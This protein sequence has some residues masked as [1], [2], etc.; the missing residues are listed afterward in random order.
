DGHSWC[1]EANAT[2]C[3]EKSLGALNRAGHQGSDPLI[4]S[5][6]GFIWD[7][8]LQHNLTIHN[9]GVLGLSSP[10]PS[11]STWLQVYADYTN[12]AGRIWYNT[13][14]GAPPVLPKYSSTNVSGFNL[15]IPDQMRADGFLAEFNAAQ[16]NGTWPT[17]NM[18]YLPND[19]T[20]GGSPGYPTARAELADNDLALGRVVEAVTKSSFWTNTVIFV[21]EDDPQSG[22]DHVDGHRSICLVISPYTKRG[23][24]VSTFCNQIGLIHT[25]EQIM[26]LPPMNQMDA[27]G[28]LMGDCFTSTPDFT[29]YTALANNISLSEMNP[30]TTG[31]LSR[32]ERYWARLSQ[33]LD[34][35]KPD[36]ASDD[37]LN[38]II[39][40]SVKG[41]ARYPSEFVGAHGKGLKQL[42]LIVTKSAKGDEDD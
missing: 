9:Y 37:V 11:G 1:T 33:K 7:N 16:S 20:A 4:Y 30:G 10:Q 35:S 17:F 15:N 25:M 40:H 13:Y 22:Y 24:T 18:L 38:R 12:H 32:K 28:P 34:F 36:M 6:S 29:T 41:D 8:V 27:S 31:A 2:D 21:I 5:S 26:G 23:Q 42:G 39:W 19:H 3:W 14:I